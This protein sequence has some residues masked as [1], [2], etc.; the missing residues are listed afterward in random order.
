MGSTTHVEDDKKEFMKYI[1]RL[2]RLGVQLVDSTSED[3][4]F[5]PIF[6]SLL[7]VEVNK[8]KNHD[9]VFIELKDSA[10]VKLNEFFALGRDVILRYQHMLCVPDVDDLQTKI[11]GE[12]HGSRYSIQPGS[13][14]M[15]HDFKQ[16]YDM[17]KHIV[18]YVSKCHN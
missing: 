2:A 12:A 7:V 18:E 1:H 9:H 5:N 16:I 6:V 17:K 3:V 4:L 14:K 13:T 11:V 8:G 10:L 15:Y